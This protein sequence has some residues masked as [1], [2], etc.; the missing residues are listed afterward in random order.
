MPLRTCGGGRAGT[1]HTP[2]LTAPQL[3]RHRPERPAAERARDRRLSASSRPRLRCSRHVRSLGLR[4]R[5][6]PRGAGR[7][8]GLRRRR[9]RRLE[10][11]A[12]LGPGRGRPD[13]LR[14]AREPL[15]RARCSC[16][17]PTCA[18]S[19]AAATRCQAAAAFSGGYNAGIALRGFGTEMFA[20]ASAGASDGD[21]G[22]ARPR[23]DGPAERLVEGRGRRRRGRR[24]APEAALGCRDVA[25][26]D[27]PLA[28]IHIRAPTRGNRRLE[29]LLEAVNGDLQVKAWWHM[30]GVNAQRLGLTDH[31]W[32]HIQIVT[33]IALR[34]ARLLFRRGI[35][36]AMVAD[37]G[38]TERDAEVVDRG[39]RALPLRGHVDPPHRPRD[40]LALPH[41]RQ[42]RRPA[43]GASTP[44]PSARSSSPRRCTR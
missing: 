20:A 40:L 31:S 14:H 37:H 9:G 3:A 33:N 18:C 15:G 1:A 8:R 34:L 41:R 10:G 26:A 24:D 44:S 22:R 35:T 32:V 25:P 17:P 4:S 39:G 42:A 43:G 29:Q 6:H 13:A 16:A 21:E 30:A 23:G 27:G 7:G 19:I 12:A 28:D 36:P 2:T 38:M 11:P 5:R